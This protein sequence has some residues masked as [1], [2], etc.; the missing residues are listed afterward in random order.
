MRGRGR[1]GP[2]F[3]GV[4]A[5][6]IGL[7]IGTGCAHRPLERLVARGDYE[8]A[9]ERARSSKRPPKRRGARA[10]AA[11]LVGL[12]RVEEAKTVLLRDFRHTGDVASMVALADVEAEDGAFGMAA[13]HYSRA[14]SLEPEILEGREDVC[15]LLRRRATVL[16]RRGEAL[17]ADQDMRRVSRLCPGPEGSAQALADGEQA[18]KIRAAAEADAR[19]LRTL[20]GCDDGGC[21]VGRAERAG[22]IEVA[23]ASARAKGPWELRA[24]ARALRVQVRAED[25]VALLGAELRGELGVTLVTNDELRAWI[26]EAPV[27]ALLQ[28]TNALTS[29]AEQ[30]YVRLRLGR[31]GAGYTLPVADD[32]PGSE[33]AL[34]TLTLEH[35]DDRGPTAAALGWRALALIGDLPAAEMTLV[36]G[37][38]EGAKRAATATSEE[39]AD[40]EDAAASEAAASAGPKQDVVALPSYA[41]GRIPVKIDTWKLMLVLGRMRAAA[42]ENDDALEIAR[43]VLAEARAHDF[44]GVDAFARAE[45]HDALGR[46]QPWQAMAIADAVGGIDALE[47]AAA[48][49]VVLQ[50]AACADGCG[51]AEDRGVVER[52]L[53]DAWV[54]ARERELLALATRR[55]FTSDPR[56]GDG[57]P[58][59]GELLTIG[60]SGELAAALESARDPASLT[61]ERDLR[62]AIEA[63]L[64]LTCAGRI[65]A[66]LMIHRGYR[67]GAS[68]LME[69][70]SQ[71]PQM[72][73]ASG[74]EVHAEIALAAEQEEQARSLLDAA[75][76]SSPDPAGVWERAA[77][78][79]DLADER[80]L[81]ITALRR[82]LM[83]APSPE[84]ARWAHRALVV[85][86]LRDANDAW[87]ARESDAG[88]RGLVVAVV[89]YL[90]RYAA[91]ERW[92]AREALARALADERWDDELAGELV[93]RALWPEPELAQ[94]H[95]ANLL[96]EAA[97]RG[98][99]RA[100][101]RVDPL[102]PAELAAAL[103]GADAGRS[104]REALAST[105]TSGSVEALFSAEALAELRIRRARLADDREGRRLAIAV[106]TSGAPEAR[107]DA[108]QVL[109]RGL[110]A[111]S[112][113]VAEHR[114]LRAVEELLLAEFAAL[115]TG[116]ERAVRMIENPRIE[117]ELLFDLKRAA[118]AEVEATDSAADG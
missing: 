10:Y 47:E 70:L 66:P 72:I 12:D 71:A 46:G 58:G 36:A 100:P 111:G 57:C 11:A 81:R 78:T 3:A 109:L 113:D 32:E 93:R 75:S 29:D 14:A 1:V 60:A 86:A 65:A 69:R 112:G 2:R 96:L 22:T 27:E 91:A 18:A 8:A 117:L 40:V 33:A 67:V 23:L 56:S 98:G 5:L 63:D 77:W 115:E 41:A 19:A 59:L 80:E 53:G 52:V 114:A 51:E 82:I 28:A 39:G 21:E 118:K 106:A 116:G 62:R 101:G 90:D 74:L 43:H 103:Q 68:I 17:A 35:L 7:S 88:R 4:A 84:R 99:R 20:K 44:P 94:T 110:R 107:A 34:V 85:R 25:V 30:A 95:P 6:C 79:G 64:G 61:A 54:E 87:A 42:G 9:V 31:L 45:A 102:S 50:R 105:W 55:S 38:R 76:A 26:G 13:A 37:L 92:W 89:D 49:A 97:L 24:E 83:Y 73:S 48:G 104:L 108:L 15:D 16:L